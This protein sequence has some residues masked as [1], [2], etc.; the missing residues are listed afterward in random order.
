MEATRKKINYAQGQV[1]Q[2][3]NVPILDE[4]V[5][6]RHEMALILGYSSYSELILDNKMAK[7]P[8]AVQ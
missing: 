8:L 5:Q 7:N 3:D 2:A 6:L 4:L 1:N